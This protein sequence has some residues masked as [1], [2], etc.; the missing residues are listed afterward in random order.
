V[1]SHH[2]SSVHPDNS[3]EM[4][5]HLS[6]TR[7]ALMVV[8]GGVCALALTLLP[9]A[10]ETPWLRS[11]AAGMCALLTVTVLLGRRRIY[12][13]LTPDGYEEHWVLHTSGHRWSDVERFV[14]RKVGPVEHV[15]V[16]PSPAHARLS[17]LRRGVRVLGLSDATLSDTY[18]RSARDLADVMNAWAARAHA[19]SLDA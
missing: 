5:F 1:R 16:V 7:W 8:S 13:R 2:D 10:Q 14:A 3:V 15:A 12:L 17:T 6:R 4:V 19:S 11:A 18:G 9:S